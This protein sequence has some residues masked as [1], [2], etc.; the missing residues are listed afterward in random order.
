MVTMMPINSVLDRMLS[1]SRALEGTSE[2]D[3]REVPGYSASAAPVWFPAVDTYENED[4]FVVEMDIP[5]VHPE[6]VEI[7]FEQN[8]LTIKGTRAATVKAPEKGELRLFT[9]ERV[10]GSFVRAI[11]LP[12]YVDGEKIDAQYGNGV[13]TVTVPK[14]A[15]AR[16]RKIAIKSA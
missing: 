8:T 2:G 10:S 6:N 5:G 3:L 15:A 9:S 16:P 1:L 12:E 14:S 13:L 11:R 7:N 4:T